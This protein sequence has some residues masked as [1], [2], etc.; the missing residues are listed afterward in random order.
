[1]FKTRLIRHLGRNIIYRLPK[2]STRL[3]DGNYIFVNPRDKSHEWI[4]QEIYGDSIYEKEFGVLEGYSVIDVGTNI[5][6]FSLK[7]AKLVGPKGRVIAIEP[8]TRCYE[9]LEANVRSNSRFNVTL[10]NSAVSDSEA[11]ALLYLDQYS[12]LASLF[13]NHGDTEIGR[14]KIQAT[15]ATRTITLDSLIERYHMDR[16]D[17]ERSCSFDG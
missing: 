4:V 2:Y 11:E 5:G 12:A 6:V 9:L 8:N 7:A 1:M 15:Q 10:L 14:W 13:Q 3:P 17:F 16:V